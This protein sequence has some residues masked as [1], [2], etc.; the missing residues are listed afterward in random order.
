MATITET[1]TTDDIARLK[2]AIAKGVKT[3]KY[4]DKEVTYNS[5]DDMIKALRLIENALGV[6]GGRGRRLYAEAGKGIS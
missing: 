1:W 6:G 3:V 4:Q 2:R 5:I